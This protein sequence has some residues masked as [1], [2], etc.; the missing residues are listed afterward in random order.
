MFKDMTINKKSKQERT[1]FLKLM[2]I[3]QV[4]EYW[5]EIEALAKAKKG[6]RDGKKTSE[7]L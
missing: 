4:E 1:K 3:G 2:G 5:D 6:L 7:D